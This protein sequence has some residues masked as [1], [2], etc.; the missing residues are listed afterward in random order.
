[1]TKVFD[2]ISPDRITILEDCDKNTAL[3]KI[4][5]LL[6]SAAG[7]PD[8]DEI[9]EAIFERENILSTSIGLGIAIPHV[10]LDSVSEMAMAIGIRPGAGIDYD[11]F[12]GKAVNIIIMIAAPAG[13]HRQ[14]LGV[15]AKI[16]LLLKNTALRNRILTADTPESIYAALKGH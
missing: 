5:A 10:R 4:A 1:M 13:T 2:I 12:D 8:A 15:L 11:A 14:Y 3:K 6:A 16:A 7:V 9:E